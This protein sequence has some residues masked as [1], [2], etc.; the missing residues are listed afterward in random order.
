MSGSLFAVV[1]VIP[2]YVVYVCCCRRAYN[3]AAAATAAETTG[4]NKETHHSLLTA[5]R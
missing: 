5:L 1:G 3:R 4:V 2:D